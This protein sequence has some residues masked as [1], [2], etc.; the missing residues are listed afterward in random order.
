[1]DFGKKICLIAPAAEACCSV[2]VVRIALT[3]DSATGRVQPWSTKRY[4]ARDRTQRS[5][6]QWFLVSSLPYAKSQKASQA[7]WPRRSYPPAQRPPLPGSLAPA[8]PPLF[9]RDRFPVRAAKMRLSR[10]RRTTSRGCCPEIR[11]DMHSFVTSKQLWGR[12]HP[13][14]DCLRAQGKPHPV[15]DSSSSPKRERETL[16]TSLCM[17]RILS[18]HRS[19]KPLFPLPSSCQ[20]SSCRF[21]GVWLRSVFVVSSHVSADV[22]F[23]QSRYRHSASLRPALPARAFGRAMPVHRWTSAGNSTVERRFICGNLSS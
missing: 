6:Y 13:S 18:P 15:I 16:T 1:M 4:L 11:N 19:R 23:S 5:P 3:C 22:R 9:R 17:Y 14:P 10:R 8:A 7:H 12:H 20:D 2:V 21:L